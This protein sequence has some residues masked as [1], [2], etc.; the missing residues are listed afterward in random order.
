MPPLSIVSNMAIAALT[1]PESELSV[2]PGQFICVSLDMFRLQ[3]SST[4][5]LYCRLA[6][7]AEPIL[8]RSPSIAITNGDIELLKQRGHPRC[9]LLP[10]ISTILA[11]S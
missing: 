1:R 2:A 7:D 6:P 8:Y 5:N 9:L 11:S 4:V 3:R 10:T